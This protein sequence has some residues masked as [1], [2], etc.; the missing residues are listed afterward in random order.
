MRFGILTTALVA[1]SV[2]ATTA[3]RQDVQALQRMVATERAFAAATAEV[4]IRDGFLSFF[5]ADAVKLHA[6]KPPL[7]T[8]AREALILEPMQQLPVVNRLIWEPFTGQISSDGSLGWLTG[9][10]V[11]LH[12]A[13]REV[14]SQGAYFSVWK[15]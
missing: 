4:G 5:A 13:R 7:L 9:G 1:V 14:T 6:G 10:Y 3:F 2:V 8:S 11:S 15:R 12:V